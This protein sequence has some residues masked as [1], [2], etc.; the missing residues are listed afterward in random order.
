[1]SFT[2]CTMHFAQEGDISSLDL[3]YSTLYF[4]YFKT[5]DVMGVIYTLLHFKI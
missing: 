3:Y 1:M 2:A 5:L 4:H